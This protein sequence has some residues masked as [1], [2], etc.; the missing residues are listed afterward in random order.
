MVF[1][2]RFMRVHK[3][4]ALFHFTIFHGNYHRYFTIWDTFLYNEMH[5]IKYKKYFS[6]WL[7]SIKFRNSTKYSIYASLL[8]AIFD[9]KRSRIHEK[10]VALFP[11]RTT[12][13]RKGLFSI[14]V[15]VARVH[16]AM[17]VDFKVAHYH[18]HPREI[19]FFHRVLHVDFFVV[20]HTLKWKNYANLS[21]IRATTTLY[22]IFFRVRNSHSYKFFL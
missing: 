17:P 2:L 12:V 14:A 8:A 15:L 4:Y 1:A 22:L 5:F 19:E 11:R 21:H 7:C 18:V 16:S 20:D 9:W 3:N 13:S 10:S 6:I